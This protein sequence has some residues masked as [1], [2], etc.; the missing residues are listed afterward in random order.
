MTID[1]EYNAAEQA[2]MDGASQKPS[3]SLMAPAITVAGV[4]FR[5]ADV[6]NATVIIDG[7]EIYIGEE[8]KSSAIGFAQ[9][10]TQESR[11]TTS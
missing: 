8:S 10:A 5:A 6:K 4:T 2:P 9:A 7:R 11:R 3:V 1:R